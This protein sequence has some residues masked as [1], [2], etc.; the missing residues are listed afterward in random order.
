MTTAD[1]VNLVVSRLD[2]MEKNHADFRDEVRRDVTEI[3]QLARLT[4]GRVTELER[5]S[6]EHQARLAERQQVD[7]E[8]AKEREHEQEQRD[9]RQAPFVQI[10]VSVCAG[11][12]LAGSLAALNHI[13]VI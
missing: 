8:L 11:V 3:K 10:I 13:G 5:K 7:R 2:S 9:K 12:L 1:L 6:I 4:N